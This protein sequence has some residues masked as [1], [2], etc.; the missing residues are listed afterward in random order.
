MSNTEA[1]EVEATAQP[2]QTMAIERRG[3]TG[4]GRA[5]TVDELH[6][7]LE[8]VRQVMRREMKEGTDYGKIPGTGDKPT[9]L[10]PGAQ[11]LLMTFN[12][13]ER[14]KKEA[15]REYPDFHREYEFTI[16]VCAQNGKEW[17]GVGTC[18]TLETKYRYRKGERKC[19]SCGKNALISE[20]AEYLQVGE[21]PGWVCWKKKQGCGTRFRKDHPQ[22]AAEV[23]NVANPDPADTWNTVRKMAFKRALVAATI[24]ATNT[25]ELWT[26]DLED[27]G[28]SDDALPKG[29]K[30]PQKSPQAQKPT[31]NT[32][33]PPQTPA[34]GQPVDKA[35]PQKPPAQEQRY[36]TDTTRA[37]MIR[38][39]GG[40]EVGALD[41]AVDY[42]RNIDNALMPNEDLERLPLEWVPLTR[43]QLA[44]LNKAISAFANGNPAV[45][46][47]E[48]N[49]IKEEEKKRR[50][51]AAKPKAAKP[52]EVPR[53][54]NCDP[55]SPSAPWRSFPVPFGKDAGVKL[56]D[57][58]K[59]VLFG[60]WANY[61]VETEYNGRAKK[62]ETIAKD[63]KFREMLDE[64]GKHYEFGKPAGDTHY[65]PKDAA[66]A[67]AQ[68][69]SE[70]D[71]A[72]DLAAK[73][74]DDV[75]F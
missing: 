29:G 72:A 12:L 9:L 15:L 5:L 44:K 36:A 66:D 14:V 57:L 27:G 8:F 28:A 38:N 65:Q 4:V 24:N 56:T 60:W 2:G 30:A 42:F 49:P 21:V 35:P 53:D 74:E 51:T 40:G 33:P 16:T 11:K 58:D 52:V 71:R 55:N 1:I 63:R 20:K 10:Q 41:I 47:Y 70:S 37:W 6:E 46:P 7:R 31:T 13:T 17:D 64:A 25:S 26:Q 32:P 22:I 73:A 34:S 43:E 48:P 39:L 67:A 62:P 23:N 18:S 59:K 54:E 3:E 19:P 45:K 68:A 69:Q 75:P 61:K 50:A